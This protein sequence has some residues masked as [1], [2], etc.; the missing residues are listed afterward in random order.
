MK[1]I[2][3]ISFCRLQN[4]E[5]KSAQKIE[6]IYDRNAGSKDQDI[7]PAPGDDAVNAARPKESEERSGEFCGEHGDAVKKNPHKLKD[8]DHR[9]AEYFHN[10]KKCFHVS[11]PPH[12]FA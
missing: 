9:Q 3:E 4:S 7:P 11:V 5:K 10:H 2:S 1:E 6:E 8:K 12:G